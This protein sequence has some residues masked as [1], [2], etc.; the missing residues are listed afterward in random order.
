M[1]LWMT[2]G[3]CSIN[4]NNQ[5]LRAGLRGIRPTRVQAWTRRSPS[6]PI[7]VCDL[8]RELESAVRQDSKRGV[9]PTFSSGMNSWLTV[10]PGHGN[11]PLEREVAADGDCHYWDEDIPICKPCIDKTEY[12]PS[13]LQF[14]INKFAARQNSQ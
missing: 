14:C 2:Q 12:D 6:T 8:F 9:T 4:I 1:R 10:T 5:R 11:L 7:D 3:D 13:F